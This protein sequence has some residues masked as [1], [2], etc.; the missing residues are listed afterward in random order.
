M[1]LHLK[2]VVRARGGDFELRAVSSAIGARTFAAIIGAIRTPPRARDNEPHR[3]NA[4]GGLPA[5]SIVA[6]SPPRSASEA[7]GGDG[8]QRRLT[9]PSPSGVSLRRLTPPSPRGGGGDKRQVTPPSPGGRASP[10]SPGCGCD[11]PVGG[12]GSWLVSGGSST[13]TTTNRSEPS[14]NEV[15]A[16]WSSLPLALVSLTLNDNPLCAASPRDARASATDEDDETR[17][18]RRGHAASSSSEHKAELGGRGARAEAAAGGVSL[19]DDADA[20]LSGVLA[21][22]EALVGDTDTE[23]DAEARSAGYPVRFGARRLGFSALRSLQLARSG[24]VPGARAHIAEL[25][26]SPSS[27]PLL[28]VSPRRVGGGIPGDSSYDLADDE[29]SGDDLDGLGADTRRSLSTSPPYAARSLGGG[30]GLGLGVAEGKCGD[31]DDPPRERKG[32]GGE[33][34]RG[35]GHQREWPDADGAAAAARGDDG[36]KGGGGGGS[37]GRMMALRGGDSQ[38]GGGAFADFKRVLR[39]EPNLCGRADD[40]ADDTRQSTR[41]LLDRF[42]GGCFFLSPFLVPRPPSADVMYV[43]CAAG[44]GEPKLNAVCVSRVRRAGLKALACALPCAAMLTRLDLSGNRLTSRGAALL[45]PALRSPLAFLELGA[46][47][48][49]IAEPVR[50]GGGGG[51]G[52][53]AGSGVSSPSGGGTSGGGE[54]T[55]GL[56]PLCDA[57]RAAVRTLEKLG[58]SANG[59]GA[60]GA[61]VIVDMLYV[62]VRLEVT[63]RVHSPPWAATHDHRSIDPGHHRSSRS[64]TARTSARRPACLSSNR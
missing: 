33:T 37:L 63:R 21:L 55:V 41:E 11:S 7:K 12:G 44:R 20:D 36:A 24:L 59:I 57:L 31:N 15:R 5:L 46:N 50:G 34:K 10:P 54:T 39:G 56:Q 3:P 27:S 16:A 14:D 17:N 45:A 47:A 13:T 32:D 26:S 18:P 60:G 22:A 35:G 58:L 30:L 25:S 51:G 2:G 62:E 40:T 38:G 29:R 9:P 4:A 23:R 1:T 8:R 64:T 19:D 42:A 28:S 61:R 6:F 52:D 43:I 53:G 48:I 49:A